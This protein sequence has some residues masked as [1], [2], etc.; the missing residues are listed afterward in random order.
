MAA[1][2]GK[3][4]VFSLGGLGE[5]GKNMTVLEY[6][7]D[8]IIID[9]GV[10][11]PQDEML[12][13]DLVIPDFTYLEQ[14]KDRIR[15]IFLTHAHEDHIGSVPYFLREI[16]TKLYGTKL[17]LGLVSN[18]LR[19][20]GLF[21]QTEMVVVPQGGIVSE[22]CFK[23]EFIRVNHSIAD[24]VAFAITTPVGIVI[25]S[26][27]FKV[28]FTPIQG[29]FIDLQRFGELG[30]KGVKL[31]MCESTNVLAK[32]YTMSER[33]V[34]A[35]FER[36][37]EQ[38][39]TQRLIVACFS[40]HIDRI[41]Q[42]LNSAAQYRRKV[43][44][45]GR[46]MVNAVKTAVEL[47][48]LTAPPGLIIELSEVR[49]YTANQLVIVTTGSQGEPMAALSRMAASDHRQIVITPSDKVIISA[50][51]IPGNEKLVSRTVNDLMKLGA[52]VIYEGLAE[53]HVSG[54]AREEELKLMHALI[55]PQYLMP[56][57]GEY[58]HLAHH[59]DL[60]IS[61]G[62]PKENIF[63]MDIGDV[64]EIDIK[65]AKVSE[66]VPSGQ[67]LVDGLGIGDVG[68][69]VL[70]DRKHLSEDGMIIVAV[71]VSMHDGSCQI[72]SGPDL[73]SRGFVFVREAD[74]LME[75][76]KKVVTDTLHEME[77]KNTAD[78]QYIKN[79]IKDDLR[80]YIWQRTKRNPMIF[81]ILVEA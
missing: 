53:V 74:N 16:K 6:G 75:G 37:F 35:M 49:N 14:N 30:R 23:I 71:G 3:L 52:E 57:H 31:F 81:P 78:K 19:E 59:K 72:I 64:L 7:N 60:A 1:R 8:I 48:Y 33:S 61:M 36:V 39:P 29:E 20:H 24:S 66:T 45:L 13:I 42:V 22:G 32:G 65:T 25:H 54:H 18:K 12:G 73:T 5:V 79:R 46:S 70:R 11:F 28:D 27:D 43:L 67:L 44:F 2:K 10:A 17:T 41:Q 51:P 76:A 63:V 58:R 77:Q 80:E 69:V 68:N 55:K 47:G 50:S 40:S 21:N 34:G 38:S 9:C 15:G 4:K 56:I 62:M 26:G